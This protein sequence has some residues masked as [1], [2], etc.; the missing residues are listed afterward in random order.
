MIAQNVISLSGRKEQNEAMWLGRKELSRAI[1]VP[2]MKLFVACDDRKQEEFD[3]CMREL[4]AI[5]ERELGLMPG[6]TL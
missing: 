3:K 4:R 6:G 1:A 5:V 2:A